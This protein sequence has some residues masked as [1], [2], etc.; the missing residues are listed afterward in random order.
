MKTE[1]KNFHSSIR[2]LER[3]YNTGV[4]TRYDKE[5]DTTYWLLGSRVVGLSGGVVGASKYYKLLENV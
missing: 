5:K 4:T 1:Q 2:A 3:L